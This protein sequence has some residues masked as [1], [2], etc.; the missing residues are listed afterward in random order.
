MEKMENRMFVGTSGWHYDHWKGLFYPEGLSK[1]RWL[2]HYVRHFNSVEINAT[3][4]S[5][6]ADT[7][8]VKWREAAP[9]GFRY[10]LKVPRLITHLKHLRGV[11]DDIREFCRACSLLGEKRGPL[12]LQIAPSM[13]VEPD[14]LREALLS[15]DD[16]H[17]VAVEFR[18]RKWLT[19]KTRDLLRETG[20]VFCNMDSPEGGFTDWASPDRGY[21]R[22]HGR[23]RW[24]SYDYTD[25]ELEAAARF[26]LARGH[27][28]CYVFFNNDADACAVK[29]AAA[30]RGFLE[31]AGKG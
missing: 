30:F 18:N 2:G 3:F 5:S 7:V 1:S 24:Y 10:V 13:P 29:N 17:A 8:Y 19:D 12:L 14:L 27:R 23:K 11:R 21:Y 26:I 6:F 28:E 20:S 4:Y 16:P 9:E 31:T 22:L 15:F 25:A